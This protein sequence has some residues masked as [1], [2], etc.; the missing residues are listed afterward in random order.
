M[1]FLSTKQSLQCFFYCT[2]IILETQRQFCNSQLCDFPNNI[3][4]NDQY[5]I[6]F[7]KQAFEQRI[8]F[9][10]NCKIL[11]NAPIVSLFIIFFHLCIG[12]E[13]PCLLSNNFVC[14]KSSALWPAFCKRVAFS[15]H[16]HQSKKG[17][18]ANACYNAK[19]CK[20]IDKVVT[21]RQCLQLKYRQVTI[22]LYLENNLWNNMSHFRFSFFLIILRY[23]LSKQRILL[24]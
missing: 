18:V 6:Q 19:L 21:V 24:G 8:I 12:I 10:V 2:S 1:Y 7:E 9:C 14:H 4:S 20:V 17:V 5:Y 11:Q 13:W 23:V 3:K 15:C 22:F 16:D